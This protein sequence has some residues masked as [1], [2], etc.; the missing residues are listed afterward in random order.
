[1]EYGYHVLFA[2]RY[3]SIRARQIT[4]NKLEGISFPVRLLL[5]EPLPQV[6]ALSD[7]RRAGVLAH[8]VQIPLEYIDSLPADFLSK[9]LDFWLKHFASHI[10]IAADK[11][12][13]HMRVSLITDGRG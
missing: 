2:L 6:S 11:V 9:S 1:M 5:H 3:R 4:S 13:N 7:R 10:R 8:Q 12:N